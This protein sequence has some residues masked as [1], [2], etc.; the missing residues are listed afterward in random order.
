VGDGLVCGGQH[1]GKGAALTKLAL[2]PDPAAVGLDEPL[3]DGESEACAAV[4]ASGGAVYLAEFLK[5]LRLLFGAD[6]DAGVRD[7]KANPGASWQG[8]L[9]RCRFGECGG[10]SGGGPTGKGLTGVVQP[11]GDGDG[12]LLREAYGVADEVEQDLA[13][14]G[15]VD[16]EGRQAVLDVDPEAES[17]ALDEVAD[18]LLGLADEIGGG[19][20]LANEA[21]APCVDAGEV[22]DVV[23]E[24]LEVGGATQDGFC[25]GAI[26]WGGAHCLRALRGRCTSPRHS[27]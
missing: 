10:A 21:H 25:I 17:F 20:G 9:R 19:Y 1:K 16:E 26:G 4:C 5:D 2:D 14:A 23:D 27:R 18:E 6:A 12:A 8:R 13:D 3:G 7:G 24:G 15:A 22:E 11:A